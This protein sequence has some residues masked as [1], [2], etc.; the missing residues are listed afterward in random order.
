MR[1]EIV[2]GRGRSYCNRIIRYNKTLNLFRN[3]YVAHKVKYVRFVESLHTTREF[4][5]LIF[6]VKLSTALN[7]GA[8]FSLQFVLLCNPFRDVRV[9]FC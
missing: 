1:N 9:S 6:V 4:R 7:R 3:T 2:V 5:H 8:I